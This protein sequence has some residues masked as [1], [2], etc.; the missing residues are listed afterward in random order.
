MFR[1]WN[2]RKRFF[3]SDCHG[4]AYSSWRL[5]LFFFFVTFQ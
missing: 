4:E 3:R 1:L 2:N 5:L